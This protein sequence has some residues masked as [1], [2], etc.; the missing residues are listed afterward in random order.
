[1]GAKDITGHRCAGRATEHAIRGERIY[2][3]HELGGCYLAWGTCCLCLPVLGA[4][5]CHAP[6][7]EDQYHACGYFWYAYDE[8][9]PWDRPGH[10]NKA[11]GCGLKRVVSNEGQIRETSAMCF[12]GCLCKA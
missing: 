10:G 11:R 7:A 4:M 8:G 1:M 9:G 5:I 2:S 12:N 6:K 3:A